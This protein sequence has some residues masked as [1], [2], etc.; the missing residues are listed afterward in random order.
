VLEATLPSVMVSLAYIITVMIC[1]G[2]WARRKRDEQ[3]CDRGGGGGDGAR[4]KE[5]GEET[6]MMC[7]M[8]K[9]KGVRR[10]QAEVREGVREVQ[11]R[12]HAGKGSRNG[13][14]AAAV[15]AA[16]WRWNTERYWG[17]RA[18]RRTNIQKQTQRAIDL[19]RLAN[20]FYYYHQ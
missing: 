20:E 1:G 17:R 8:G 6:G 10:V 11:R 4:R 12:H 9:E 2:C 15:V 18:G 14:G 16:V 19:T 5:N 13:L 7:W 3:K